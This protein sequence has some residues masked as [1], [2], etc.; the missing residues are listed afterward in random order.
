MSV[1]ILGGMS[2]IWLNQML[3][4]WVIKSIELKLKDQF[5]Q[6]CLSEIN[7]TPKCLCYRIFKTDIKLESYFS[8]LSI[9]NQFLLCKF[10]CGSHRLPIETGRWNNISRND[11]LCHLCESSDVGDEYH[12]VM[13]CNALTQERKRLL[14]YYCTLRPNIYKYQQLITS[15]NYLF[16]KNFVDL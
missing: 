2:N 9:Y 15:N 4:K 10:R 11:R 1:L 3:D 5:L 7:T 12:Y 13:S 8:K 14:P 6:N 16:L